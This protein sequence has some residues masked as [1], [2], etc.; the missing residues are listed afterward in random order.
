[1]VLDRFIEQTTLTE[2]ANDHIFGC[3]LH[4]SNIRKKVGR[5]PGQTYYRCGDRRKLNKLKKLKKLNRRG[6]RKENEG[7]MRGRATLGVQ[8]I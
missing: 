3:G 8:Y 5:S 1:M 4:G 2:D 7:G 6:R